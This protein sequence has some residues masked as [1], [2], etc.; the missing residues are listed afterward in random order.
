M[1]NLFVR[2]NLTLGEKSRSDQTLT[3]YS[4]IKSFLRGTNL[5]GK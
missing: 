5:N 1:T 4:L 2:S 3:S